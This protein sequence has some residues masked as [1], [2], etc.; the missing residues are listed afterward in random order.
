MLMKTD[1]NTLVRYFKVASVIF[2][3]FLTLTATVQAISIPTS[4]EN[5]RGNKVTT[6]ATDD[7]DKKFIN[8]PADCR[9]HVLWQWMGGMVSR[10][11]ITKDLEAM[12]AQGIGG[13]M[14]MVM[15]DQQPWPY[16]FSYRDYPGKV[17]V[18]SDEWFDLMN[19][20]IGESDRLGLE[21]R[22]FACTGWSH[23]GGPWVP[24]EK[25]FKK[26][27]FSKERATGP[28]IFDKVL[29]KAHISPPYHPI[30][31]WNK[32]S[33]KKPDL[34]T[35]HKDMF[36]MAVPA[37]K[38]GEAVDPEKII[39]LTDKMDEDGKLVWNV[40]EGEWDIWRIALVTA[41]SLN[42][43]T[44]IETVGHEA[45]RMDPKAVRLVYD[46]YAGRINREARAKGYK[47]FKGFENDSYES[48]Y[49]DFGHDFV[50]EFK[51]RR[52]YDCTLWLPAWK[53]RNVIIKNKELTDRFHWDMRRTVS[54]LH[55]E[56]FHK[57]LHKIAEENDLEW[58]LEPYFGMPVDW[59]S[60]TKTSNYPGVEFWVKSH[61]DK[62]GKV[63]SIPSEVIG[64][65]SE[66][67]SL[68]GH[69][70]IWS[71]A[72]T[73]EPFQSAWRNDPWVLKH[74]SDY[75]LAKGVNQFYLHG[76]YHNS[77][78]DDYQPGF[79]MGYFGT[80]FCRHL[81][82]WP[83]AGAWHN[84]L[85]RCNFMMREG[86]P[87]ADALV[88]PTKISDVPTLIE[89][90][91]RQVCLTDDVLMETLSVRDGK[92]V[93]PHGAQF[94]ALILKKGERLRPEMLEKIRDLVSQGATLISNPP[95]AQSLSMENYPEC[96]KQLQKIISEMW[97]GLSPTLA[98]D[99]IY[100][101]GRVISGMPVDAAMEKVMGMPE[102]FF[103]ATGDPW[104]VKDMLY[105]Q[106][107]STNRDIY[108]ISQRGDNKVKANIS[109]KWNG[110]QPEWWDAVNGNMRDLNE[111]TI[112]DGRIIIPVEMYPRESGFIVFTKPVSGAKVAK[113]M[114][115]PAEKTVQQINSSWDVR[116]DPRWGGPEKVTF[117]KLHDW[118]EN[119]DKRIS[120]YSGIARY[121][122]LF[123]ALD[124]SATI[125]DLGTV[126]NIAR[127]KINGQDLGIVWCAPWRV[128]IPKGIL[129]KKGN[130][131]EVEVANTWAN[132]MIGDEQQPDDAE[133]INPGTPANRPGGYDMHT[134]GYGLKELPDWLINGT[135]RPSKERYTFTSWKFYD[136]EAPLQQSGLIGP[137]TLKKK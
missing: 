61:L 83:F 5:D 128:D 112:I 41:N 47:S 56:R 43:P 52:G 39:T 115:F 114:N 2:F 130:T 74:E 111:Y 107:K 123:D 36:V 98:S 15:S 32:D 78:S 135:P 84:Y 53:D 103:Q 30:P 33:Q 117:D 12:A 71:E 136:K 126:K 102:L 127:V 63:Q 118:A 113:T 85:A 64:T 89:G 70:I 97:Y 42:H 72:F 24:A 120:Y 45:D 23:A 66:A 4:N 105:R 119:P 22:V 1:H 68:Y 75:A 76:F 7:L 55:E 50:F 44:D 29:E 9:P 8:P 90:R 99:A 40:P 91:Y 110:L 73:A 77:F 106:R 81:T 27:S 134:Q 17:K 88:Y 100:G 18:L 26:L 122:N 19:F 104:E 94:E 87:I 35:Y 137:V 11:G 67:S 132:R 121:T 109:I 93:L 96:D 3:A 31:S 21:V 57:E 20:A 58:L 65:S 125:L 124:I 59:Q 14:I 92:L 101:K 51:K 13:T 46:N 37:T 108:F 60:I 133:F 86:L 25:S 80:Q 34:G 6:I 69:N 49:Q 10:E 54:E 116:F 131:I 82:W 48:G 16:V 129:K 38:S 28:A 95:P 62:Y 79:T